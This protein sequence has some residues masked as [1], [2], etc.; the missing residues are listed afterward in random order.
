[1]TSLTSRT[2][3]PPPRPTRGTTTPGSSGSPASTIAQMF[4]ASRGRCGSPRCS[5]PR[6][7]PAAEVMRRIGSEVANRGHEL[8]PRRTASGRHDRVRHGGHEFRSAVVNRCRQTNG[9]ATTAG[10]PEIPAM[11]RSARPTSRPPPPTL[12][13]HTECEDGQCPSSD[14][15]SRYP[16]GVPF[17]RMA[18]SSA[19]WRL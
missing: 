17:C 18:F 2:L 13:R 16:P 15:T 1:M 19:A 14:R 4:T 6:R 10:V 11:P 8:Q 12:C 5:P 3:L 7:P 9:A